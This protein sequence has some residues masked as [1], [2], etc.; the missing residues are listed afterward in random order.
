MREA[1]AIGAQVHLAVPFVTIR[2]R[3]QIG[4]NLA[5][6]MSK[7]VGNMERHRFNADTTSSELRPIPGTEQISMVPPGDVLFPEELFPTGNVEVTFS[8]IASKQ[9]KLRV[10]S[11]FSYPGVYGF[12]VT[13]MYLFPRAVP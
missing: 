4:L 2:D 10:G 3:V 12:N 1:T 13:F 5:G 7:V 11:G 8:V 9:I 6:G